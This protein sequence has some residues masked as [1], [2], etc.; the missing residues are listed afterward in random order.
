MLTEDT[1]KPTCLLDIKGE[2]L[3][4]LT[5]DTFKPTCVLDMKTKNCAC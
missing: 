1:L 4:M 3:C 5:E 2:K